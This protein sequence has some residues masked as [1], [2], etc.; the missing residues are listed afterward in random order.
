MKTVIA[1]LL[2]FIGCTSNQPISGVNK[3]GAGKKNGR[4]IVLELNHYKASCQGEYLTLCYLVKQ[5]GEDE[6]TYFYDEIKNFHYKWGYVYKLKVLEK[7]IDIENVPADAS[8]KSYELVEVIS[9]Q[10]APKGQTF[11]ISNLERLIHSTKD[12]RLHVDNQFIQCGSDAICNE[13]QS[14]LKE[15]QPFQGSFK[16]GD[17]P[18]EIILLSMEKML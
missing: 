2:I 1:F 15:H 9:S 12:S 16:H 17:R 14:H 10:K 6:W 4:E 11:T 18:W 13:M 8:S 7:D 5:K 3:T